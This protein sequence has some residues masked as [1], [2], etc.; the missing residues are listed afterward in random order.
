MLAK[1]TRRRCTLSGAVGLALLGAGLPATAADDSGPDLSRFYHQKIN[2]SKCVGMEAPRDLQCGKITV[3][4][5]Y[6]HPRAGT[7]DLA[8]ARYESTARHKRGSVVLNFGGPGGA[9]VPELAAGG[10]DF[11]DLTDEYDVVSF[12]PR[13]VGRSSPVSC[14]EGTDEALRATDDDTALSTDP[15]DVLGRL[16]KAAAQCAEHSG[17]VLPHIGTVNVSRDLDVMRQALGDKKLNYLGFSY[18]SRLGA[19]YAAQFP[20]KVGRLVLDGVDTLTEPVAEQGVAGAAGQQTALE[21]F[22]DWCTKDIACPFGT[23]ARGAREQVVRLVASLDADPVPTDF[24]PAFTGQDLVGAISQALYSEKLWPSLERALAEL[25]EDGDTTGVLA[26]AGG[27]S[28]FLPR[29]RPLSDD[30]THSPLADVDDI[31]FDNLPAALM[32]VNCADDPDRPGADRITRD[33][34]RLRAA[35]EEASPVFGRYRLTEYLMCY[36][37]PK[38]TDYIREQVRDVD[39][40]KILLVGTRGDPAT[41]YRWTVETAKRLGDSAVVLD[42]KGEGHT[43]YGSSSCVHRKVDDFLLYGNLPPNGSSCGPER[44]D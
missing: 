14:G 24:G 20:E 37:R 21:D 25:V 6:A 2:W 22:I 43:G 30:P 13:G 8:L 3:P 35:Y 27:G 18:G 23:D 29:A 4:V 39:T 1:V 11:M 32:A 15:Q 42:N 31:P 36:G 19:V 12:D 9:G 41:P 44:D 33:L 26:F 28:G 34:A 10:H 38:G 17:P 5:D 16:R 40:P 7:L